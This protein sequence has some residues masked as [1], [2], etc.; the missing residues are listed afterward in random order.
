[1][2][3]DENNLTREESTNISES[4][5]A[6]NNKQGPALSPILIND[7]ITPC[8]EQ[9]SDINVH[10]AWKDDEPLIFDENI[11]EKEIQSDIE[12]NDEIDNIFVETE[13]QYYQNYTLLFPTVVSSSILTVLDV[14]TAQKVQETNNAIPS[15]PNSAYEAFVHLLTKHN[16]SNSV[17]NDIISLFNNFHMD[18]MAILPSNAKAARKLLDSMQI[19]H[20]LYKKTVIMEYNQKQYILYHRTIYDTI[21]ELLSNEDIFKHCVFDFMP[22]YLT[23]INGENE[24]CYGEQYNSEWWGRA[25]SSISENSKVLSIILYSDATT[26]DVLAY[27]PRIKETNKFKKRKDCSMVKHYLFQC[28]LEVL[29]EPIRS[30]SF[31]L[32]TDNGI[33]WC[34]PFLSELLGDMP[35]HHSLTLTYSSLNCNMPCYTCITLRDEFNNPLIDH[36]TIQLRTPIMMQNVLNNGDA[37]KYSLHNMK[38]IFWTL[39]QLNI[40]QACMPDRMHHLDLGLYKYQVEYTRD[41]L[42]EWCGSDGVIEFDD[43]LAKIPRFSGLKLF[44]HGLGNIKRFTA[45]EFRSMMR[46]LVFVVDEHGAI[47]GFVTE[48]Y[49]SLHKKWVKNPYRISN[50]HDAT[51][52]MLNTVRKQNIIN[53]LF[54]FSKPVGSNVKQNTSVM[55][56]KIFTFELSSFDKFVSS[57]R[58]TTTLASEAFEAFNQFL[59]TL[60]KFFNL[61]NLAEFITTH[62]IVS[63][64][65]YRSAVISSRDTVRANSNWYGQPIF[66]NV[67]INMDSNEIE[68][69]TTYDGLCF[70]K[71]MTL[72]IM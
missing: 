50:Q 67:S 34:Y 21:K 23:N 24:R 49:E 36:S 51:L 40:Y 20:I 12:S 68:D 64:K 47:N 70:G 42:A 41:L 54:Q 25:Q 71:E 30:G 53:Y 22:K 35:E 9:I 65:W 8:E 14:R 5:V 17:A 38:N 6:R 1:M 11:S 4:V 16:L 2:Y 27:L 52:Q 48:T 3:L 45:E 10:D 28:S 29:I 63:V 61:I 13:D 18:S 56:G 66:D 60:D 33:I 26:C 43:R 59:P 62:L 69:Y 72:K 32:R 31:D 19:P 37:T 46:Q 58:N 44:K 57:Y 15:F 39:P 7:I 55:N